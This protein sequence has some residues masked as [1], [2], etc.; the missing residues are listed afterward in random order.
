MKVGNLGEDLARL[1]RAQDK[2]EQKEEGRRGN[3]DHR[4]EEPR[5]RRSAS[6]KARPA[7]L[8]TARRCL[9]QMEDLR[10]L[11]SY[12]LFTDE[13][14]LERPIPRPD[15][16][17][18]RLA[19]RPLQDTDA[20]HLAEVLLDR[21][22]LKA[23]C[24]LCD[25]VIRGIARENPRHPVRDYLRSLEWDGTERISSWLK[26]YAGAVFADPDNPDSES[27]TTYLEAVSRTALI[28]AVARVMRPGAKHDH[29]LTLIGAQGI[30]KCR[31][32]RALA[33]NDSWFSDSLTRDMGDKDAMV[34]LAGVWICE[35]AELAE[36]EQDRLRDGE[37][38]PEPAGRQVPAA[39]WPLR[40][41]R[42]R[43]VAFFATTNV[44]EPFKDETG[45]SRFWPV[46]C[47]HATPRTS[48]R[49]ATSSGPRPCTSTTAARNGGSR[50]MSRSSRRA[51]R[52]SAWP[53]TR[54]S[55]RSR[56]RQ[57]TGRRRRDQD[58][59]GG[60]GNTGRA[61]GRASP[62][63]SRRRFGRWAGRADNAARAV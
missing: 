38:V 27:R 35:M 30:G 13:I 9:Q 23:T 15:Y 22:L 37:G 26:D 53:S 52:R 34:G 57:G 59:P 60:L 2:A 51:S 12:D 24:A 58:H 25:E 31:L 21:K 20:T 28:G 3:G 10:G 48:P 16:G 63:K 46:D 54:S 42:P 6:D 36:L 7:D 43:Q 50:P 49:C 41:L 19:A 56:M 8:L 5:R 4:Q 11:V 14:V 17:S 55:R 39:L 1:K 44:P 32:L 40:R 45:N 47:R 62:W 61:T 33:P 29:V 18:G